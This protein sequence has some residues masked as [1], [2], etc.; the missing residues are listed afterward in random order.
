MNPLE[1]NN[2]FFVSN[3]DG[4]PNAHTA[5]IT[6]RQNLGAG[7]SSLSTNFTGIGPHF[8]I[9]NHSSLIPQVPGFS[10]IDSSQTLVTA[11]WPFGVG[12]NSANVASLSRVTLD[13]SPFNSGGLPQQTFLQTGDGPWSITLSAS[14]VANGNCTSAAL[15]AGRC[16]ARSFTRSR[17]RI[18]GADFFE[19]L[20][21]SNIQNPAEFGV[22]SLLRTTIS[23]SGASVLEYWGEYGAIVQIFSDAASSGPFVVPSPIPEPGTYALMVLGVVSVAGMAAFRRRQENNA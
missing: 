14:A 17:V 12:N 7:A 15:T 5:N 23:G 21:V 16:I 3:P 1:L 6:I 19:E 10:Q 20:A 9:Q 18:N 11:Q 2:V 8:G 13:Y 22:P 4:V